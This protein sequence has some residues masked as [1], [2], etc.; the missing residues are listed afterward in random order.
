MRR[1]SIG[2]GLAWTAYSRLGS[3]LYVICSHAIG[4]CMQQHPHQ[5]YFA[6][7]NCGKFSYTGLTMDR[8]D[9]VHI[10]YRY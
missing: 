4:I 3:E 10:C 1:A 7:P 2:S 9:S 5:R 6:E 8:E